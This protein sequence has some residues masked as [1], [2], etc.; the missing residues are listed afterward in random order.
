MVEFIKG[1]GWVGAIVTAA[2]LIPWRDLAV[3]TGGALII[4][5]AG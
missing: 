1:A 5:G 4:L 3:W 2:L